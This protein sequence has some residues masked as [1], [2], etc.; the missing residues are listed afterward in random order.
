MKGPPRATLVPSPSTRDL[1]AR[2]LGGDPAAVQ[3]TWDRLLRTVRGTIRARAG[4]ALVQ[5]N[6]FEDLVQEVLAAI[7]RAL[8]RFHYQGKGSLEAWV[9]MISENKIRSL[10]R[11]REAAIRGPGTRREASPSQLEAG[12][13]PRQST[14]L[15]PSRLLIHEEDL[16]RVRE[17]LAL[18]PEKERKV[19]RWREVDRLTVAEVARRLGL[20]E[21]TVYRLHSRAAASLR[22]RL[23]GH[24]EP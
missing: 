20:S 11:R 8:P 14:R 9:R 13:K 5:E 3:E 17:G 18:L 4:P 6:G 15:T 7:H 1:L 16:C 19:L 10:A 2:C 22:S 21:R 23:E 24:P 12:E